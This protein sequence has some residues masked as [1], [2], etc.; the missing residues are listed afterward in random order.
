MS[1]GL[2]LGGYF[3]VGFVGACAAVF[4]R[5]GD[6]DLNAAALL[7]LIAWPIMGLLFGLDLLRDAGRRRR[8]RRRSERVQRR[9]DA[10]EL[11]RELNLAGVYGEEARGKQLTIDREGDSGV[12]LYMHDRIQLPGADYGGA[13]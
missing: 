9:H 3:G 2:A 13:P 7:L 5:D 8:A 1:F 12:R 4:F 11:E 10:I 6:D